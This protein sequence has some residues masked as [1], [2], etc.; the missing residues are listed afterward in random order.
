[1]YIIMGRHKRRRSKENKKNA[2]AGLLGLVTGV[3]ATYFLYGTKKG[4]IKR[5]QA[6]KAAAKAR[7]EILSR[8]ERVENITEERYS[9]IV[10]TVAEKYR[11]IKNIDTSEIDEMVQEMKGHWKSI[12][13]QV[14]EGKKPRKKVKSRSRKNSS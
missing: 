2:G 14:M 12:K 1:M 6:R 7:K 11:N 3:A 4:K 10:D 5:K 13:K 9:N 8:A